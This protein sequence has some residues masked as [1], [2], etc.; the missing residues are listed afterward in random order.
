MARD[1][2]IV[3]ENHALEQNARGT[4]L[5]GT[6][7]GHELYFQTDSAPGLVPGA[8]PFLCAML[9]PAMEQ[10]RD[11]VIP[12]GLTAPD[13]KQRALLHP[14]AV[15]FRHRLGRRAVL[16]PGQHRQRAG[17]AGD[18]HQLDQPMGQACTLRLAPADRPAVLIGSGTDPTHQTDPRDVDWD[19]NLRLARAMDDAAAIRELERRLRRYR[20][21]QLLRQIDELWLGGTLKTL[22]RKFAT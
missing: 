17:H 21:K 15:A 2:Q 10:A 20:G 16:R 9:V 6:V 11:I 22:K 5:M 18:Q 8:E 12:E 14:R 19:D 1:S 3:L 4:R 7:D 13:R